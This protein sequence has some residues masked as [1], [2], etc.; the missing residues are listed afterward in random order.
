M[1]YEKSYICEKLE[2]NDIWL[3][4]GILAIYDRQT[5]DEKR[6]K[7]TIDRNGVGFNAFD[8]DI[9][10][11]FAMVLRE[12]VDAGLPMSLS[13]NQR[14]IARRVMLKYAGQLVRIAN[15]EI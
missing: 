11:S 5:Q 1:V 13:Y 3:Y 10:S 12:R 2:T 9:M 8:A 6:V 14:K 4:R 7:D 15:K